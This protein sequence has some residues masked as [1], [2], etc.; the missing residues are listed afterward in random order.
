[1]W[2][3]A[4]V[5]SRP[6][7]RCGPSGCSP[8]RRSFLAGFRVGLNVEAQRTVIDVGYAGVI[9]A[10]R[11]TNGEAPYGNMPRQGT[12][13]TVRACRADGEIRER[14][15]TNGRCESSNERGDTYGPVT[16]LAYVPRLRGVRVDR[17]VGCASR[18]A[19]DVD[20]LRPP[21]R[22]SASRS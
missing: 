5:A 2:R 14:I 12:L 18:S 19:R 6:H 22:C 10:D 15:Q 16:Y 7:G 9:G 4:G 11:I 17:E 8:G 1:M 21:A 13:D 20:P 3:R